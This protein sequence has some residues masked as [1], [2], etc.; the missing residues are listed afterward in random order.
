MQPSSY[1]YSPYSRSGAHFASGSRVWRLLRH[2]AWQTSLQGHH[3]GEVL[4][5][6]TLVNLRDKPYVGSPH[7]NSAQDSYVWSIARW[8]SLWSMVY[9]VNSE[10]LKWDLVARVDFSFQEHTQDEIIEYISAS[11]PSPGSWACITQQCAKSSLVT[12]L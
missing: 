10:R 6:S 8:S 9:A 3:G 4:R 7:L 11:P 1:R 5:G 12:L 2:K